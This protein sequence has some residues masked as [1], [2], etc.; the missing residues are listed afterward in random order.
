[1]SEL[2][3]KIYTRVSHKDNMRILG[4]LNFS[5]TGQTAGGWFV[6]TWSENGAP[7]WVTRM[8]WFEKQNGKI[9]HPNLKIGV[10]M[11]F[12]D[13][14]EEDTEIESE[15][16]TLIREMTKEW[17]ADWLRESNLG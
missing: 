17:E 4:H 13:T 11:N 15:R 6:T 2:Y 16:A 7:Y 10:G 14:R 1:V 9:Y 8:H 3:E 5:K 12:M